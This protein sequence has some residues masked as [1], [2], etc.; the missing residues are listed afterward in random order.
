[1]EL[2]K[3]KIGDDDHQYASL[4]HK[5]GINNPMGVVGL[6]PSLF[7]KGKN[8]TVTIL[9]QIAEREGFDSLFITNLY[10]YISPDPK[11]LKKVKNPV[12]IYNDVWIKI[13]SQKC[14]KILCI[15]G[16]AGEKERINAV[17][18][19]IKAKAYAIGLTKSGQPRHVLHTKKSAKLIKL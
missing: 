10:S 15:W 18:P 4:F 19:K 13:M 1:M 16:N 12:S 17:M 9:M 5:H 2:T 3:I 11:R 8:A 14:E 7:K 6:N